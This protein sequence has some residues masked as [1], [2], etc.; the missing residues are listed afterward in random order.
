[1][2]KNSMK[3]GVV[4]LLLVFAL[5]LA[6]GMEVKF[7]TPMS[8]KASVPF[9]TSILVSPENVSEFDV[10]L[11]L[12]NGWTIT[13]WT[14]NVDGVFAEH[15]DTQYLG[16]NVSAFRW[17]VKNTT[18]NVTLNVSI[19]PTSSEGNKMTLVWTYPD[20]FGSNEFSIKV[21]SSCGN[22]VCEAGENIFNC[23]SDCHY[24]PQMFWVWVMIIATMI[25]V[26]G[27]LYREYIKLQKKHIKKKR[28]KR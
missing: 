21:G 2:M 26:L 11:M 15:R 9:N 14:S 5:P 16:E 1:M 27:I 28:K 24:L 19:L 23:P 3:F 25:A 7:N 20:G 17:N 22:N 18:Q 10:V 6:Y 8:A 12:P 4:L 13:N